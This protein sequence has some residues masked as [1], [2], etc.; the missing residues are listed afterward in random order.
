MNVQVSQGAGQAH[1]VK[2]ESFSWH[3]LKMRFA[4]ESGI[5]Q[6]TIM[7]LI[8]VPAIFTSVSLLL[9]KILLYL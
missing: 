7:C 9:V 3:N 8:L 2:M 1:T 5:R 4:V 6:T